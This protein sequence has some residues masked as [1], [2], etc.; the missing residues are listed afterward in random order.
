M[1]FSLSFDHTEN[2]PSPDCKGVVYRASVYSGMTKLGPMFRV[3]LKKLKRKSCPGCE[4]CD[5]VE[6]SLQEGTGI[7]NMNDVEDK[8]MY[9]PRICNQQTDWETGYVDGYDFRL[10]EVKE[11]K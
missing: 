9:T 11:D 10:E 3:R 7:I 4:N 6:E 1:A 8:K 2:N 5:W